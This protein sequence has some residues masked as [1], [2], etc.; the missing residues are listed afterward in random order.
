MNNYGISMIFIKYSKIHVH[1]LI[2]K[3]KKW[4]RKLR[5]LRIKLRILNKY[6]ATLYENKD[7]KNN[8]KCK[9]SK[10]FRHGL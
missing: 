2:M 8:G 1:K 3:L 4:F 6:M 10:A 5:T 7:M 9:E